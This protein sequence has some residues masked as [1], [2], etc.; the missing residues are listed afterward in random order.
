MTDY[1]HG[2]R[3]KTPLIQEMLRNPPVNTAGARRWPLTYRA[4]GNVIQKWELEI[5][6]RG[7]IAFRWGAVRDA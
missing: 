5:R 4:F 7:F 6:D 3:S 2:G 1:F